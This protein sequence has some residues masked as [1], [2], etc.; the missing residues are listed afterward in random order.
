MTQ[1]CKF[2]IGDQVMLKGCPYDEQIAGEALRYAKVANLIQ[3]ITWTGNPYKGDPHAEWQ[4][5][6]DLMKDHLSEYWFK[7]VTAKDVI[8]FLKQCKKL[9]LR[10][11]ASCSKKDRA[12][13]K[14]TK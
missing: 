14:R 12:T 11:L 9:L 1:K 10:E 6:T 5:K 13:L 8:V 3:T 4:V 7:K 2:K